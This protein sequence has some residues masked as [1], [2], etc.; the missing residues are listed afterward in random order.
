MPIA[1]DR[2]RASGDRREDVVPGAVGQEIVD[3]VLVRVS[4]AG[5]PADDVEP[6]I[7]DLASGGLRAV[8]DEQLDDGQIAALCGK[9][10][11]ERVVSLITDV[12]VGAA[13]EEQ[14]DDRF[15]MHAEVQ[16]GAESGVP[17]QRTALV[18]DVGLRVEHLA[19]TSDRAVVC[20]R[21]QRLKRSVPWRRVTVHFG[22]YGAGLERLSNVR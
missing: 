1:N 20:S 6:V 14:F 22:Q 12:R 7:V 13:I 17:L 3:D 4:E 16:R 18:D 9:V 2:G 15:V 10:Q 21:E 8:V 19:H 11:R 5:R